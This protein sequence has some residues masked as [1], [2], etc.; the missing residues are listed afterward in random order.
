[1][2]IESIILAIFIL[3]LGVVLLILIR[4]IPVLS[5]LSQT[6]SAGIREHHVV[7]NIQNR[8]SKVAV[9]FEKQILFHKFLSFVKVTTMKIETKV[10]NLLHNIRKNNKSK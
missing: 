4:K 5:S 8:M 6:G 3:S 7:L 2:L 9:F 1:M 10:D